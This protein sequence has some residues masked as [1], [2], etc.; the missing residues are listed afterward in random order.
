MD[1]K[2]RARRSRDDGGCLELVRRS[3]LKAGGAR[4]GGQEGHI[5]RLKVI[6]RG[7]GDDLTKDRGL[8]RTKLGRRFEPAHR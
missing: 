1:R 2:P 5:L 3:T 8:E 4:I 7:A 6:V